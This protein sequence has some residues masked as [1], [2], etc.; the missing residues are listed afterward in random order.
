M[1]LFASCSSLPCHSIYWYTDWSHHHWQ[2]WI[3]VLSSG[4]HPSWDQTCASH[5]LHPQYVPSPSRLSCQIDIVIPV[6]VRYISPSFFLPIHLCCL[7]VSLNPFSNRFY[8]T[9]EMINRLKGKVNL[10]CQISHVGLLLGDIGIIL[11]W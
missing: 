4:C 10:S 8:L 11:T 7:Q 3:V 9:L 1:K 2:N 5:F 6:V